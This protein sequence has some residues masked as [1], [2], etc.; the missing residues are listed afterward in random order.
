MASGP[1][2]THAPQASEKALSD[3]LATKPQNNEENQGLLAG[4]NTEI[5]AANAAFDAFYSDLRPRL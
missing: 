2:P 3:W 1:W 5:E 4:F